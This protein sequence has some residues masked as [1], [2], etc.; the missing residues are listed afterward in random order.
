LFLAPDALDDRGAYAHFDAEASV[1]RALLGVADRS[2][3]VARHNCFTDSAPL[4]LGTL[5]RYDAVVTDERPPNTMERALRCAVVRVL[6]A[7]DGVDAAV[8]TNGRAR[9]SGPVRPGVQP[10]TV[11]GRKVAAGGS[12]LRSAV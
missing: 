1:Q 3:V 12:R 2:V 8:S 6:V 4:L 11:A 9:L 7:R 10:E 5:N